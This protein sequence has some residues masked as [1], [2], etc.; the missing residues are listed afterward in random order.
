MLKYLLTRRPAPPCRARRDQGSQRP[1]CGRS[2]LHAY[3]P[4]VE[5]LENRT[6]LS[7]IAA[8][9][10]A[11]GGSPTSV[12]AGDFNGDGHPDIAVANYYSGTVSVLLSKG[13]GTFQS[14]ENLAP[15]KQPSG[16]GT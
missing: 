14:P 12:A 3:H 8:P 7:F 16:Q 6:L 11:A 5:V 2:R 13:D 15:K 9:T 10:Y 1:A 4:L